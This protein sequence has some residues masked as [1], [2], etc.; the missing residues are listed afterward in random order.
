LEGE[1][2]ETGLRPETE[3]LRGRDLGDKTI[4]VIGDSIVYGWGVSYEESYP[5]L[6]EE[7][8]NKGPQGGHRWRVVNAGVPGN[9]VLM[10]CA[11]YQRDVSAFHPQVVLLGY[12]LNDAALRRTHI[13]LQ[14]ERFWRAQRYLWARIAYVLRRWFVPS[15]RAGDIVQHENN[16]RVRPKLYA[17]ALRDLVRRVRRGGAKAY[18]VSLTP[19]SP[20]LPEEQR[21]HYQRYDEIIREIAR[22][23]KVPLI[24]L[25]GTPEHPFAPVTMWAGDGVH[26]R[27]AGQRW[28]AENVYAQLAERE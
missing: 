1:I 22:R 6:L 19:V 16:P 9:T 7:F 3:R 5:A 28:V 14:R 10:G 20:D 24:D 4:V 26:L 25:H 8:L 12:G 13:D 18:L 15:G 23:D 21:W 17:A 27:A 2:T 11:R